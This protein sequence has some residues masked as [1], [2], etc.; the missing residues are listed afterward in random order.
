MA[1]QNILSMTEIKKESDIKKMVLES[2]LFGH[3]ICFL[4]DLDEKIDHANSIGQECS[5]KKRIKLEVKKI[6]SLEL[7]KFQMLRG[8][9]SYIKVNTCSNELNNSFFMFV[10]TNGLDNSESIDEYIT[11]YE[12]EMSADP[13]DD[14]SLIMAI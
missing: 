10:I 9:W 13:Y 6:I 12:D 5:A 8:K 4:Y 7:Y 11:H 2:R 3:M 14:S 1:S